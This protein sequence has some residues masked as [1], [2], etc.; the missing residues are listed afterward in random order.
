M[1]RSIEMQRLVN[2]DALREMRV[3]DPAPEV[4]TFA[5]HAHEHAESVQV[6]VL[7]G[8]DPLTASEVQ[9]IPLEAE[10]ETPA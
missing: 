3:P 10:A 6:P 9:R 2:R 4:T 7:I 5:R 8:L 1:T